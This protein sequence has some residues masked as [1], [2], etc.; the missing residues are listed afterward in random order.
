MVSFSSF[1]NW[2]KSLKTVKIF[3]FQTVSILK[4]LTA[5][6]LQVLDEEAEVFVVKMWRLLIYEVEAK[7]SGLK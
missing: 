6:F 4:I 7:R 1:K 5:F 3:L 2:Q